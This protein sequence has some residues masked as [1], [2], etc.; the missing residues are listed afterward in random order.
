M[1]KTILKIMMAP[2]LVLL[3]FVLLV[4]SSFAVDLV[5]IEGQWTPP[6]VGTTPVRMWGFAADTGQQCDS[7]PDWGVGPKLTA[8]ADETLTINLRNC[9]SEEVSVFIPGQSKVTT[10]VEVP[11]DPQ[12]IRSFDAETDPEASVTYTWTNLK[13]GTYIYHSGTNLSKQVHMGLYGALIVNA[14]NGIA[15]NGSSPVNYDNEAVLFFSEIDPALHN[16]TPVAANP[17]NYKPRYFL[18]NGQPYPNAAPILNHPLGTNERV[19]VR[20]ISAALD[21]LVP[22][23]NGLHWNLVAEDGNPYP[24]PKTQVTALLSSMKT[25]DAILVA[26]MEGTYPVFDRRFNITN[27]G[28]GAG[29]MMVLLQAQSMEGAPVATPD[30]MTVDEGGTVSVL[31]SGNYSVLDND[32]PNTGVTAIL[33]NDVIRGELTFNSDG[34][35]SYTHDG[36]E[37]TQDFFTYKA[38][39]GTLDSN[40]ATVTIKITPVNDPPVAVDDFFEIVE[41]ETLTVEAPGVLGNDSDPEDDGLTAILNTNVVGGTLTLN[42]NGS[43]DYTPDTGTTTDSFTYYAY[44]G[45]VNSTTPATVTI[46]VTEAPAPPENQPPLANPDS[47]TTTRNTAV[48]INLTANDTDPDGN[49][50]PASVSIRNVSRG[51]TITSLNNG[52][53]VYTPRRNFQGTDTFTY[54]VFDSGTPPL[55]SNEATVTVTVV[56]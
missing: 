46:T 37:T 29:G 5:A 42:G 31:D 38:N 53:V 27:N 16:P 19:L 47:A 35:F 48:T 23:I 20:M 39:D 17:N 51:V 26:D 49:L 11:G 4:G 40:V 13:A 25:R 56:R 15:Y 34:T 44:D 54:T 33:V 55:E 21:D 8:T 7:L 41:G 2:A 12:R 36:S 50:D 6:G 52:S 3:T 22:T 43:F 28:S 10:P 32:V 14:G 30:S 45:T 1:K 18:V 24:Y 9:L